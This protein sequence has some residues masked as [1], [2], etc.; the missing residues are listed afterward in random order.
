MNLISKENIETNKYLLKIEVSSADFEAAVDAAYKTE[1]KKMNVQG[2]RAGKAPRA[3]IEKMYGETVFYDAAIDSLYRSTVMEAVEAS[4]LKVIAVG[5]MDIKEIGKGKNF[6]F[7]LNVT[8]KP[9]VAIDGYKG[10]EIT[11]EAVEVTDE[12]IG[13]ELTRVQD[14]NSRMIN[15]EDK[16]AEMGNTVVIDFDGYVNDVA[17]D[18]G[19]SE[20]FELALGSGQFI[21]GFEEQ[22]VG[23]SIGEEFDVNVKFPEEYHAEELKGADAVFKIKLH[24]I[25]AKELPELD[26]EFAK[27]VSEFDTLEEYKADIKKNLEDGKVKASEAAV[28]TQLIDAVVE[29]LEAVIPEEMIEH[30]IDE[31]INAFAYRLQSQGLDMDTYLKYTGMTKETI[32][33]QFKEQS[34]KNVKVRLALE[35][36]VELEEITATEEELEAEFNKIAE[37]YKMPVDQVKNFVNPADLSA[38]VTNQKAV[39]LIKNNAVVK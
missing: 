37:A 31:S 22:V 10:I 34:E 36:I 7:D 18:G 25:K 33:E 24:E 12:E 21:P 28:D 39:E 17:F 8:T 16:A 13:E 26:D 4:E 1:G 14:R 35:K 32:R 27:D 15:I 3:M 19:K 30:E 38:D 9:E 2:F 23:H 20:N 6:V 5:E 29:K 11:K